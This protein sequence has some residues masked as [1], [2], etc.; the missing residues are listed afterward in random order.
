MVDISTNA[1]KKGDRAGRTHNHEEQGGT[2]FPPE[3][4]K[5]HSTRAV[6]EPSVR[7]WITDASPA[8]R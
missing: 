5:T 4:G 6:L 8:Y 7:T 2:A 1:A 3:A